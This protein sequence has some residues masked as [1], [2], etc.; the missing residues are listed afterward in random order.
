M[1]VQIVIENGGGIELGT[2]RGSFIWR[3]R[4]LLEVLKTD[5]LKGTELAAWIPGPRA[6]IFDV[7]PSLRK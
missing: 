3:A 4:I 2:T 1:F 5:G 6:R 7:K